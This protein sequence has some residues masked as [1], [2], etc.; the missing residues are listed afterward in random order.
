MKER[1]FIFTDEKSNKFWNISWDDTSFTVTYG[2]IGASGTAKTTE[3]SNVENEVNKLISSKT[4]KGYVESSTSSDTTTEETKTEAKETKTE[5][6]ETKK[7]ET[8][9]TETKN[10]E[11]ID[12]NDIPALE[13]E[14]DNLLESSLFENK[15][16]AIELYE[17]LAASKSRHA[18][19]QLSMCYET[20]NGVEINDEKMF[21]HLDKGSTYDNQESM[22]KLAFCYKLGK[23][24]K[25]DLSSAS[26]YFK[27]TYEQ[28]NYTG[29]YEYALIN[30]N[31]RSVSDHKYG[32]KALLLAAQ[33]DNKEYSNKLASLYENGIATSKNLKKAIE[34]Y[35]KADNKEKINQLQA[36]YDEYIK[37][38]G[39]AVVEPYINC[40][41]KEEVY[42]FENDLRTELSKNYEQHGELADVVL[43]IIN[44]TNLLERKELCSSLSVDKDYSVWYL[45]R[46]FH[47]N[48]FDNTYH[49]RCE[50]LMEFINIEQF[51]E[52][53]HDLNYVEREAIV[54][55]EQ[56]FI[57]K[58]IEACLIC[59]EISSTKDIKLINYL[60]SFDNDIKKFVAK[61]SGYSSDTKYMLA[62]MADDSEEDLKTFEKCIRNLFS[63]QTLE[64]IEAYD[65]NRSVV[66]YKLVSTINTYDYWIF[67]SPFMLYTINKTP[68]LD[69]MAL[70]TLSSH[71]GLNDEKD[72]NFYKTNENLDLLGLSIDAIV[73]FLGQFKANLLPVMCSTILEEYKIDVTKEYAIQ[74][75]AAMGQ[76]LDMIDFI[77]GNT[78]EIN[79]INSPRGWNSDSEGYNRA[80][81][82]YKKH[83]GEDDYL[84]RLE[85]VDK[86]YARN[87]I[88]NADY[89]GEYIY[90]SQYKETMF[91]HCIKRYTLFPDNGNTNELLLKFKDEEFVVNIVKDSYAKADTETRENYLLTMEAFPSKFKDFICNINEKSKS[92]HDVFIRIFK[93]NLDFAEVLLTNLKDK[94]ATVRKKAFVNIDL[95]YKDMFYNEVKEA[96]DI[97]TDAKLKLL[98]EPYIQSAEL[99]NMTSGN[100]DASVENIVKVFN[101][102]TLKIDKYFENLPSVSLANGNDGLSYMK[103]LC[104]AY[105]KDEVLGISDLGKQIEVDINQREKEI[106]VQ[107]IYRNYINIGADFKDKWMFYFASVHGG[108]DM[109][110][111]FVNDLTDFEKSRGLLAAELVFALSINSNK[112][113]LLKVDSISRKYK[114]AQIKGSAID[115]LNYAAKQLNLSKEDFLDRIIPDLDFDLNGNK[116]LSYGTR[117][118]NLKLTTE[119]ELI[120]T[121][122]NN[123]ILKNLPTI[124]KTDDEAIANETLKDFKEL[125]KQL[126]EVI[127]IQKARLESTFEKTRRWTTEG[128][129]KLFIENPIMKQFALSL[130]WGTYKDDVLVDSFR[131]M[132]DGTFN[133]KNEEEFILNDESIIGLIHPIELSKE[134]IDTW[135]NQLQDYEIKQS[136]IQLSRGVYT[137]NEEELDK[138]F[139]DEVNGITCSP[140]VLSRVLLNNGWERGYIEDAGLFFSFSKHTSKFYCVLKI[141]AMC[142]GYS[143]FDDVTTYQLNFYKN[144]TGLKINDIDD[145][146]YSEIIQQLKTATA[147]GVKEEK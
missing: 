25:Q 53:I 15:L 102:N 85:F 127:S 73:S 144:K 42:F 115:A 139:T 121:D 113:S 18:H 83:F 138:D 40:M 9:V 45:F 107:T 37:S 145:K 59:E 91:K 61:Y 43:Q 48:V 68:F 133:T 8:K 65:F 10:E 17:K 93:N 32:F 137:K 131:Y 114:H 110:K 30:L 36:E 132:E 134:D 101:S 124:G 57:N 99:A 4:K 117:T 97:E 77:L 44:S 86:L 146:L 69:K 140:S 112:L 66:P 96:C 52:K 75:I 92:N 116:T 24:V 100:D 16:K 71:R 20:G 46:S 118:F 104:M 60:K 123:K 41:T 31:S 54:N 136:I 103:A 23:G 2:R 13:K 3:A 94:K 39:D 21:Y 129:K 119:L 126:K 122:E 74:S 33:S 6:K 7:V 141:S 14:A 106:C 27:M 67:K 12:E 80:I 38:L 130:I 88:I 35:T 70:L 147:N 64:E 84:K 47:N 108:D 95:C 58:Y 98:M 50:I 1:K 26:Y 90:T 11:T 79:P 63:S 128:F 78:K 111:I 29:A 19:M 49:I 105:A 143:D 28:G 72:V 51:A 22:V 5:V 82:Y 34:F 62:L 109:C 81:S 135:Y 56:K 76:H 55:S 87:S 142:V 125:K 89:N 120:I